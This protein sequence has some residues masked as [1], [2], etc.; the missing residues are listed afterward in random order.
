MRFPMCEQRRA[1]TRTPEGGCHEYFEYENTLSI[2]PILKG[3]QSCFNT[4]DLGNE[5]T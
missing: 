5:Q 3:K 1:D 4:T 2:T